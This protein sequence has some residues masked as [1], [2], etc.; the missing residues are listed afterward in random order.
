ME[1][2]FTVTSRANPTIKIQAAAGHFATGS[3]HRSHYIDIFEL[4]TNASEA[5]HAARELAMPYLSNTIVDVIV[6]TDGAEVLASY[7][8]DELLQAGS[9]VINEG[10]EIHI[11]T[12]IHIPDGHFIFHQQVHELIKNKN[13]VLLAASMSTGATASKVAE[14]LRYYGCRL[15]GISAIFAAVPEFNGVA[16]HSLFSNEDIP[17]Y[18]FYNLSDCVMCREKM[19]LDAII[20]SEGYTKV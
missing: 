10:S 6:Y 16:V 9:G 5:R 15:V 1:A 13:A 2:F 17:D 19:K 14:C 8:A 18:R 4:K 12:P 20:D 7:M 3:A 11:I